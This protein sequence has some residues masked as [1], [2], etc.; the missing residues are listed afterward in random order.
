LRF[1]WFGHQSLFDV[2]LPAVGFLTLPE[3]CEKTK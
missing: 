3:V 1:T 2:P